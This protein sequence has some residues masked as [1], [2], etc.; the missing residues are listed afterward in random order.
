MKKRFQ[1]TLS[2]S[3]FFVPRCSQKPA[4]NSGQ[5]LEQKINNIYK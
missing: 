1:R 3:D 5:K 4:I 2:K